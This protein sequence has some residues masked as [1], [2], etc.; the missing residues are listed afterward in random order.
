[1]KTKL[2]LILVVASVAL[3]G[4]TAQAT[5]ADLETVTSN[6]DRFLNQ[7]VEI[8]APVL[9]N[10]APQGAEFKAWDFVVG[11]AGHG[12][13]VYEKGFNPAVIVRAH[14]LVEQARLAG[15]DITITGT[16]KHGAYGPI[17]RL[18]SVRYGDA[19][20]A[21]DVGPFVDDVNSEGKPWTPLWY[22]GIKYY[23]GEF[24]Y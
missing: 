8:T 4:W 11:R 24:P 16:L 22:D 9:E 20:M 13:P 5:A 10:P 3:V 21:T 23:P 18:D 7:K 6:P 2:L 19:A 14:R 15:D 17:V 12:L 1:M